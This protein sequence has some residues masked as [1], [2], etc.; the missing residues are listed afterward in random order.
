MPTTMRRYF[1]RAGRAIARAGPY[2]LIEIVLPGGTLIALLLFLWQRS[3]SG[4]AVAGEPSSTAIAAWAFARL[5]D[6]L[7]RMSIRAL[8]VPLLTHNHHDGLE[9][10]AMA[11]QH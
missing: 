2:L 9:P 5:R 1:E 8:D 7:T 3:A 4:G 10:L 11:P 6:A